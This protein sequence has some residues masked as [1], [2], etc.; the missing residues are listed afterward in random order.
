MK[1][2]THK[3]NFIWCFTKVCETCFLSWSEEE[4]EAAQEHSAQKST[5]ISG[6]WTNRMTVTFYKLHKNS[7]CTGCSM[8]TKKNTTY[9][10]DC[11]RWTLGNVIH[12]YTH[13]C[14]L[15]RTYTHTHCQNCLKLFQACNFMANSITFL[16]WKVQQPSFKQFP[17][18]KSKHILTHCGRVTQ[19]C[20]F[21]F[22]LCKTGDANL[23]F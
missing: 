23:R 18:K 1:I 8:T 13:A 12:N 4:F 7:I 10:W 15:V 14:T 3:T 22:Q 2:K 16:I 21:T 9:T 11:Y 5:W 6:R 19:I 20:V 17:V